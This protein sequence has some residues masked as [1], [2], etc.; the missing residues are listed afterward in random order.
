MHYRET[1]KSNLLT[2]RIQRTWFRTPSLIVSL[3]NLFSAEFIKQYLTVIGV[4]PILQLRTCVI[5]IVIFK[6]GHLMW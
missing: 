5:K 1:I 4:A 2:V 6:E 3:I